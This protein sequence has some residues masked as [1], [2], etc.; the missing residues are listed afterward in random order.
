MLKCL[1]ENFFIDFQSSTTYN[2]I[3]TILK[4]RD[5]HKENFEKEY[6]DEFQDYHDIIIDE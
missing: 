1:A 3:E 5:H 2:V 4:Y 6:K